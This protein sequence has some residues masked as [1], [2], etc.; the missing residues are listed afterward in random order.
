M[1]RLIVAF[2][3]GKDSTALALHLYETGKKFSLLY[4]P[5]GNELPGVAEHI[6]NVQAITKSPMIDLSAPTLEELIAEQKCLPNWLMR[7]CTRMIKIEP[8]QAWLAQ[9]PDCT[10][11]VGLR[12]DEPGRVGTYGSVSKI[13]YPLRSWGWG[14]DEVV[15]C[16]ERFE[17]CVPQRTDCAVCFF[18]TLHEWYDLYWKHPKLYE[19]GVA[20]EAATGHTFRSPGRDSRPASLKKLGEL[21]AGGFEPRQRRRKTGCRVCNL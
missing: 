5:T 13:I 21:F 8:C 18:Q 6:K 12:A 17:V 10:L 19:Q 4:T 14:I 2:S 15:E 1:R 7:W 20:W 9:N 16:C 11:A 3:G